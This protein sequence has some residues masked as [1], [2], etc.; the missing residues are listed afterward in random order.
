MLKLANQPLQRPASP[1]PVMGDVGHL[2]F[3]DEGTHRRHGSTRRLHLTCIGGPTTVPELGGL[4]LFTD[5]TFDPAGEAC[6]TAAYT[7]RKTQGPAI[8]LETLGPVDAVLLSHE[9][10]FDT[11]LAT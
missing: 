8:A 1:R 4:R 7:L 11:R 2:L 3:I 5:P 6:P 9:H 10:H